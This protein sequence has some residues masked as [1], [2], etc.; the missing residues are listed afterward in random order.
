MLDLSRINCINN[1]RYL[2]EEY[3]NEFYFRR[4][5]QLRDE[6][7]EDLQVSLMVYS[8]ETVNSVDVSSTEESEASKYDYPTYPQAKYQYSPREHVDTIIK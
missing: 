5:Y 4:Q 6:T 1:L 8:E 7:I 3:Q 2:P